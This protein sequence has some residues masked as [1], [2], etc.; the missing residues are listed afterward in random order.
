MMK[1]C[2]NGAFW[3][4]PKGLERSLEY[5]EIR[6]RIETIETTALL[7]SA[8]AR[9]KNSQRLEDITN[10][11]TPVKDSSERQSVNAGVRNSQWV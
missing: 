2:V 6:G 9:Q 8:R 4:V 11:K 3:T 7:R 10:T 5:A 1:P